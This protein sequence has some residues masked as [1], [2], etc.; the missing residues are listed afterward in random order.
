MYGY[1]ILIGFSVNKEET[2]VVPQ[3]HSSF[4]KITISEFPRSIAGSSVNVARMLNVLGVSVKLL[5][6]V[7]ADNHAHDIT[8]M[9]TKWGVDS[10]LLPVRDGTPRTMVF[11]P[12]GVPGGVKQYCHKPKYCDNLM[13]QAVDEVKEQTK[14]C[15]P[16]YC[17]ATGVRVDDLKLVKTLFSGSGIKVL[18]PNISLIQDHRQDF[19]DLC[20]RVDLVVVNHEEAATLLGKDP[21]NFDAP[22]DVM[23]FTSFTRAKEVL[24]TLNSHGSSYCQLTSATKYSYHHVPSEQCEVIDPTGAG[25]AY[26]AGYLFSRLRGESVGK[27]MRFA[28]KLAGIKVTKIGGSN[29]PTKE[30]IERIIK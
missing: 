6:T 15:Q 26:L 24:V 17:V 13:T 28:T 29:V 11:V 8:N 19:L 4:S 25:D 30:E 7:G 14:V 10:F 16:N 5:C 3:K 22:D 21:N 9:L 18:N 27:A 23:V 12:E 2:I 1:D 20:T